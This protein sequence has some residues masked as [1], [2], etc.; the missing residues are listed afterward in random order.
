MVVPPSFEES[1]ENIPP[2]VSVMSRALYTLNPVPRFLPQVLYLVQHHGFIDHGKHPL[3]GFFDYFDI[4]FLL[5]RKTGI[6][7]R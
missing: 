3:S 5:L 4:L 6:G 2:W 1:Q 7:I